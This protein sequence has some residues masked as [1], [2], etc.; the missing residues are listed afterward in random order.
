MAF[1]LGIVRSNN[2]QVGVAHIRTPNG[3]FETRRDPTIDIKGRTL[4][5]DFD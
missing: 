1:R 3:F 2:S 5:P 4:G